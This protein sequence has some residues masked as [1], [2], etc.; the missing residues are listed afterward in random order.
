MAI[1]PLRLTRFAD[2]GA[3]RP[4]TSAGLAQSRAFQAAKA[5]TWA[6]RRGAS[7]AS[8]VRA[9][10]AEE[11]GSVR[12]TVRGGGVPLGSE[13]A[14]G[15]VPEAPD[16]DLLAGSLA[17]RGLARVEAP[18]ISGYYVGQP[19]PV[20]DAEVGPSARGAAVGRH[21]GVP[22]L[23]R[24]MGFDLDEET[25]RITQVVPGVVPPRERRLQLKAE[26]DAMRA[27]KMR[28]ALESTATRRRYLISRGYDGGIRGVLPAPA[29]LATL[30]A[31]AES[32]KDE[33]FWS[34][35]GGAGT[36]IAPRDI[37][38]YEEKRQSA[39]ERSQAA[40][41]RR[42]E[43][44]EYGAKRE[45]SMA[46]LGFDVVV[47]SIRR[48]PQPQDSGVFFDP[49][50]SEPAATPATASAA[51]TALLSP[52]RAPARPAAQGTLDAFLPR[53]RRVEAM[54]EH[55]GD[56]AAHLFGAGTDYSP[57]AV[58]TQHLVLQQTRGRAFDPVSNTVLPPARMPPNAQ[59]E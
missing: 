7:D 55:D 28:R 35:D 24:R 47:P 6:A 48:E 15:A 19:E 53:R 49:G 52:M 44:M 42:S 32:K 50:A 10:L 1:D 51:T 43:R 36:A 11:G 57:K 41:R 20:V 27:E 2:A 16:S 13:R 37:P 40:R 25:G 22:E 17:R 29:A 59:M 14:V 3:W 9:A 34:G 26:V 38:G 8:D 21:A 56:T 54:H 23:A 5:A 45:R 46:R 39:W 31:A 30:E 33:D 12:S 18:R 58:R 4:G